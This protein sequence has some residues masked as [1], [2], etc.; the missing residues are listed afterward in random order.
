MVS[1]ADIKN[2][3]ARIAVVGLGYVGLPLAVAF[4]QAGFQ[5][6]G[7]DSDEQKIAAATPKDT[8]DVLSFA[9]I[10]GDVRPATFDAPRENLWR[11]DATD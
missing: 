4:A 7:V 9:A 6:L 2:G 10:A 5:V 8:D 1:F 3:H 11:G